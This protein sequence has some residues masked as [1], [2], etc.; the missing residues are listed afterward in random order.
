MPQTRLRLKAH[1]L[2]EYTMYADVDLF[3]SH[4]CED[5]AHRGEC[6]VCSAPVDQDCTGPHSFVA[7]GNVMICTECGAGQW[8]YS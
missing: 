1:Q 6:E 8:N 3:E 7:Q 2:R 5:Y 4:R